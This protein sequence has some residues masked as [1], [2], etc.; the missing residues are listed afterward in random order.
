M[1]LKYLRPLV[2]VFLS[3]Q[4]FG[5]QVL[6]KDAITEDVISHVIVT[7][8]NIE[9]YTTSNEDGVLDI[10]QFMNCD[11]IYFKHVDYKFFATTPDI[12]RTNGFKVYLDHISLSL[13]EVIIAANRW[14]EKSD[15]IP[16]YHI[17]V[18][19]AD[20]KLQNPQTTAD[21]LAVSGKVYIQ[22]SQQG[23][24]SP[25]IRG[26]AT[27]RLLYTVD[28][29]RMN[30]A[31][32][33]GGN[34]QN[35]ISLD[36][37]AIRNTEVIFG[38]GSVIYGSDAIGGVM[39]FTTLEPVLSTNDKL[40]VKGNAASRY[41]S[42]NSEFTKHLD[43]SLGWKK[44]GMATSVSHFHYGDLH[45]GTVGPDD[46]IK[47]FNVNRINDS[48]V[49]S[50]NE[51]PTLQSP[52]GYDQLNVMQ[53]FK[54]KPSNKLEFD[55]GFHYSTTSDYSRYDRHL[56]LGKGL[57][58]YGEW[59]YGPQIWMMNHL[60]IKYISSNKLFDELKV[61]LAHQYF[62][63]SRISRDINK[64]TKEVRI[65]EV[66]AISA[67]LDFIKRIDSTHL[68]TY[69]VEY[70]YNDVTSIG[71]D[72]NIEDNTEEVGPARYPQAT[73]QSTAVFI[74]DR[75]RMNKNTNLSLGLRYNQYIMDALFDT[76]FY[77]FPYT[78]ANLNNGALTGSAGI[79]MKVGKHSVI[80]SNLAT[81]FR[82][83]NVDDLGKVFDSEPGAVIV[84][85]P[86]LKAEYAY[87]A[88]LG[89]AT[90]ISKQLKI[91][92]AIYYTYLQN[93]LVRR[94]FTLNGLDSIVYDGVMSKVQ[95]IQ[96]AAY[97]NVYGLQIGLNY[98]F[99]R[100][101]YFGGNFNFQKGIEIMDDGSESTT[102]HASP[103][104]GNIK[105]GYTNKNL[106]IQAYS[107]FNSEV[108]YANM[109]ISEIDKTEIYALDGDGNPYS[110]AWY[111]LNLKAS[112]QLKIFNISGGIENIL[113]KRYRPYSSGISAPGRNF[114][115]A[116]RIN[117]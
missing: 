95:A 73:W 78:T 61:N 87:N 74:T 115:I 82:S 108:S 56:R 81:A 59:S 67:N 53:K 71:K 44:F 50:V 52:S 98:E 8:K 96:N 79:V 51:D 19:P 20:I 6:I 5:Q 93:A 12:L 2:L 40:L 75:I 49:V 112:Y 100:H 62:E 117:I 26:F 86:D 33:R 14:K 110:P 101:F 15:D 39:S 31:I 69:G 13:G 94:D 24:G 38:P 104:F 63:E 102:R 113:D 47:P 77:P 72:I 105:L 23:G 43:F 65:E 17:T 4:F 1:T 66:G 25:M 32:F 29:V 57:P 99:L 41:S 85:N 83:P 48:D 42:A 68:F 28:G 30:T 90:V 111:T 89:F 97:A 107:Q 35:V 64:P 3:V 27:N 103:M 84:P 45:Q 76:T 91:D 70:I 116:L 11:S 58:R 18:K 37:F 22:K 34:I 92:G 54:Y 9:G 88:D 114:I 16:Q 106:N 109:P 55:Y 36:P 46:Y 10:T 21:L 60:E 7:G 80:S